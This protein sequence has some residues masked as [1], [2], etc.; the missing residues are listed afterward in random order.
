M[1]PRREWDGTLLKPEDA[2]AESAEWKEPPAVLSGGAVGHFPRAIHRVLVNSHSPALQRVGL[3]KPFAGDALAAF[4]MASDLRITVAGSAPARN[5]RSM[6]RE[7][8]KQAAEHYRVVIAEHINP[9]LLFAVF[10]DDGP[11]TN[12]AVALFKSSA[13]LGLQELRLIAYVHSVNVFTFD[14]T[15]SGEEKEEEPVVCLNDF[16]PAWDNMAFY[17]PHS[18]GALDVDPDVPT[19]LEIVERASSHS[20]LWDPPN[21]VAKVLRA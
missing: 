9:E 21:P 7:Q 17:L 2:A 16:K 19:V 8:Q 15:Y 6:S 12:D 18:D 14:G 3:P 4:L 11:D 13:L 1:L 5:F 20:R 10:G